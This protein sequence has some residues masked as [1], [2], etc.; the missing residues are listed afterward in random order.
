MDILDGTDQVQ[1]TNQPT[2]GKDM[3]G[4]REDTLPIKVDYCIDIICGSIFHHLKHIQT[5][6]N[7]F[8]QDKVEDMIK[9]L[10]EISTELEWIKEIIR[11]GRSR[12]V[13]RWAE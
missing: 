12:R 6:V 13:G 4:H 5:I 3:I 11:K 2:K 8:L 10:L 1:P 9:M 7:I